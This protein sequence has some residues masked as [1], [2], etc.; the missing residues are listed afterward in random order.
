MRL[1]L[2]REPT[3]D[4]RNEP[5]RV[6]D[7]AVC[8]GG[9]QRTWPVVG[10]EAESEQR[11]ER[12]ADVR[13]HS[14][15]PAD[16][17]SECRDDSSMLRSRLAKREERRFRRVEGRVVRARDRLSAEPGPMEDPRCLKV[18]SPL[19]KEPARTID[20][21]TMTPSARARIRAGHCRCSK[22]ASLTMRAVTTVSFS[23]E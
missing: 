11:R 14:A 23:T 21:A 3:L 15:F 16:A 20:H 6:D 4:S 17:L 13:V 19:L 10:I 18:P 8:L 12:R 2:L 7:R 9:G 5:L 22:S 1:W